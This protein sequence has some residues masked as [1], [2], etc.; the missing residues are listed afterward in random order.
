MKE[1]FGVAVG[2]SD[3]S[4]NSIAA[5]M[6]LLKV[7]TWFEKHFTEDKTQKGFDHA[8]AMEKEGLKTYVEDIHN[9]QRALQE[10][11]EKLSDKE[12]YTRKRARRSL[13]AARDIQLGELVTNEDGLIVRPEGIMDADQI[14][15]LVGKKLTQPIAQFEPFRPEIIS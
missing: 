12:R 1:E 3:H 11:K 9:A 2:F 10:P 8:Y 14:D 13:Y 7:A 15:A 6:A 5:S 4:G